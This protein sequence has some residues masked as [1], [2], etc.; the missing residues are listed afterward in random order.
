MPALEALERGTLHADAAGRATASPT[1]PR[2]TK[3]ETHIDWQAWQDV[4]N[5]IRGLSPFP[6]AWWEF[7][8]VS[9]LRILRRHARRGSGSRRKKF[10]TM[11]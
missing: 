9:E 6:G 7:A 11:Q 5:H 2:S 4:H 8:P 3:N 10:S 1:P